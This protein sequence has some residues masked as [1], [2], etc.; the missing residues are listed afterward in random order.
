MDCQNSKF[1]Q[2]IICQTFE[3]SHEMC[4]V[5]EPVR[6]TTIF[7]P[8][9]YF[10]SLFSTTSHIN[11]DKRK[12]EGQKQIFDVVYEV[13]GCPVSLRSF[14][15]SLQSFIYH[16]ITSIYYISLELDWSRP[17]ACRYF[18]K[19]LTHVCKVPQSTLHVWSISKPWSQR[20]SVETCNN[21]VTTRK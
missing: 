4:F 7:L 19:T 2:S 3:S 17:V 21:I 9:S 16:N 6:R 18:K 20:D 5:L 10:L 12:T 15:C 13:D 14:C 11:E 8:F 1:R